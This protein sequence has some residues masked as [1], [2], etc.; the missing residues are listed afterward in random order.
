MKYVFV[1]FAEDK[2]VEVVKIMREDG[3]LEDR[4][5]DVILNSIHDF[6]N[7]GKLRRIYKVVSAELGFNGLNV[8]NQNNTPQ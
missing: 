2:Q 7:E 1:M 8:D 6:L 3:A 4:S 5:H